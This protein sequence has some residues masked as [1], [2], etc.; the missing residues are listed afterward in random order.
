MSLSRRTFL[1]GAGIA[2]SLPMLD[3]MV[4]AFRRKASAAETSSSPPRRMIAI[5]TNMGILSQHFFPTATGADFELTAYL[6]ILKDF[7]SKMT[8]LSGVSHPDVDGAHGAE[9][10]FLSAAPHPGG[11]GFKN[12]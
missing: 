9:R 6:D 7:K 10:S 2:V 8:V 11:A 4:P 12:S 1:R 5:Q 3:A